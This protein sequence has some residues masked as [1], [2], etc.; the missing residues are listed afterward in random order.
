MPIWRS[1]ELLL[2][3]TMPTLRLFA[4]SIT[5]FQ[6]LSIKAPESTFY[7]RFY[8]AR[9][10]IKRNRCIQPWKKRQEPIC[11]EK[12]PL[13][14]ECGSYGLTK[15]GSVLYSTYDVITLHD[16]TSYVLYGV[17]WKESA[18]PESS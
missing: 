3:S 17:K 4:G 15:H 18:M 16:I 9:T 11:T 7:R 6:L 8:N 5:G 13:S 12:L 14:P 1:W 10:F 2:H